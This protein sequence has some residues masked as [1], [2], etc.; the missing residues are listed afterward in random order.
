MQRQGSSSTHKIEALNRILEI[1]DEYMVSNRAA[2]IRNTGKQRDLVIRIADCVYRCVRSTYQRE[3][4]GLDAYSAGDFMP[5]EGMPFPPLLVS[6]V[7]VEDLEANFYSTLQVIMTVLEQSSVTMLKEMLQTAI[8]NELT[9]ANPDEDGE[10]SEEMQ[11]QLRTRKWKT[12][13]LNGKQYLHF[14]KRKFTQFSHEYYRVLDGNVREFKSEPI[15]SVSATLGR[16]IILLDPRSTVLKSLYNELKSEVYKTQHDDIYTI[17]MITIKL[18]RHYLECG[19]PPAEL[20]H[21]IL[22]E[23]RATFNN[24]DVLLL[25]DFIK[26]KIGVCRHH[27][28]L[29]AFF[30][31]KLQADGI[32]PAGTVTHARHYHRKGKERHVWVMYRLV[33]GQDLYLVDST[34]NV[35]GNLNDS[36]DAQ[37]LK[38][39]GYGETVDKCIARFHHKT[40]KTVAVLGRQHFFHSNSFI[41]RVTADRKLI[42]SSAMQ[43]DPAKSVK[44]QAQSLFDVMTTFCFNN[45]N[46]QTE[47]AAVGLLVPVSAEQA[48]ELFYRNQQT[49]MTDHLSVQALVHT[50]LYKA[51]CAL[52]AQKQWT[53]KVTLL[54]LTCSFEAMPVTDPAT[55]FQAC[56]D[57]DL[58]EVIKFIQKGN[59]V[60]GLTSLSNPKQLYFGDDPP[61]WWSNVIFVDLGFVTPY[62]YLQDRLQMIAHECRR[63]DPDY[64]KLVNVHRLMSPYNQI[65]N[66]LYRTLKKRVFIKRK[67]TAEIQLLEK[68]LCLISGNL[69][70]DHFH[71]VL[72]NCSS[73]G[74]GLVNVE[75]KRLIIAALEYAV[76]FGHQSALAVKQVAQRNHI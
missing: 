76:K 72:A 63:I 33:E 31:D 51:L 22:N 61:R 5:N 1:L 44:E 45:S 59:Y 75:V 50:R 57:R 16:E 2:I 10:V 48:H 69:P 9:D 32:L 40:K 35:L 73:W 17:L 49:A 6:H 3:C 56:V 65:E 67:Q 71:C 24:V 29:L 74:K 60:F 28:L 55:L 38:Q 14:D 20:M 47:S 12:S 19:R 66:L 42:L 52:F 27:S 64:T 15:A 58:T 37:R 43:L 46:R 34:W 4:E 26:H 7:T 62:R 11:T 68:A 21:V 53:Q 13:V 54:P 30:L 41:T 18:V 8:V 70:L 23:T 36:V 25:D 39:Y